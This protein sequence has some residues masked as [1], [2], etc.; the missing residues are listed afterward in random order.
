ME[1]YMELIGPLQHRVMRYVWAKGPGT[2]HNVVDHLNAEVPTRK[3]AY[4][5]ILTVMR[6]LVKRGMLSQQHDGRRHLFTPSV[7]EA[8]YSQQVARF[9]CDA[10]FDGDNRKLFAAVT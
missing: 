4:T 7:T 10:Y 9:V 2:V 8:E 3:L 5:T 6:N 1:E